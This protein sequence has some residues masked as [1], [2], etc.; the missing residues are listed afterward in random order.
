MFD[1]VQPHRWQPTRLPCPWD[2]PGKNT[3]MGCHFFL[4]KFFFPQ[5]LKKPPCFP[6][7]SAGKESSCNMGNPSLIPGLGRSP[8][9]GNSH[10][11][12][13]SGLESSVNCIVHGV[14]KSQAWLSDFHFK[15]QKLA[16]ILLN[17]YW[18]DYLHEYIT[19]N[20]RNMI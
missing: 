6:G 10:P 9:K 5:S 17:I 11:L 1:S 7:S 18:T 4:Q 13:Y 2:S 3:G 19:Y 8:G 14:A 20:S 12:Q 16:L 15:K